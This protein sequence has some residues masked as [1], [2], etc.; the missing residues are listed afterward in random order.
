MRFLARKEGVLFLIYIFFEG[1]VRARF[2]AR[3]EGL[4]FLFF[5]KGVCARFSG[6]WGRAKARRRLLGSR[7][8]SKPRRLVS[9]KITILLREPLAFKSLAAVG[10]L[11]E[12][13]QKK[14]A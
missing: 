6:R 1:G 8:P 11:P 3:K 5:L 14:N 12:P 10:I 2:L 7:V 4:L 13:R 9:E